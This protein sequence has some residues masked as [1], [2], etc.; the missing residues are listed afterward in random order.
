MSKKEKVVWA[1]LLMAQL[2]VTGWV[3]YEPRMTLFVRS[4]CLLGLALM[5]YLWNHRRLTAI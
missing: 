4:A 3:W 2:G 1:V 5:A